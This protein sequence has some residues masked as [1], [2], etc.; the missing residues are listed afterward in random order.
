MQDLKDSSDLFGIKYP[1]KVHDVFLNYQDTILLVDK[2]QK[3]VSSSV[4]HNLM[5]AHPFAEARF[6]QAHDNLDKLKPIF[7]GGDLDSFMNLV[8]SEALTLHSMMMS[9]NPYFILMKPNT[10]EIINKIWEFRETTK[11]PV[12]F[13]LDAGANVHVLISGKK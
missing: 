2:G 4:G 13:T 9:S 11:L 7:E 1:F 10:M 5:H 8:E 12:C 3:Q 6:K